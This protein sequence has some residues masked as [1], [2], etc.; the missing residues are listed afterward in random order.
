MHGTFQRLVLQ[1]LKSIT[2]NITQE[3]LL[4][5]IDNV[6]QHAEMYHAERADME[7]RGKRQQH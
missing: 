5:H 1:V 4:D 7:A 3:V 6:V 2:D